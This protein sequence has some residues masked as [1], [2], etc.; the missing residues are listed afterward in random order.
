LSSASSSTDAT[1]KD[2]RGVETIQTGEPDQRSMWSIGIFTGDSPLAV[3]PAPLTR[4]PV[5]TYRDVSDVPASFVADPFMV[6]EGCQWYLFCEVK[7]TQSR[8][9]EIGLATSAD[10]LTWQYLGIVLKEPFH[11]SYPCVFHCAGEYYMVPE[12]LARKAIY[13]YRATRFPFEWRPVGSL[14]EGTFADPT[15]FRHAETWW[16]FACPTPFRHETLCLF[17]AT[18]LHGP[19]RSHPLNP[20]VQGDPRR[21]RPGGRVTQWNGRLIRYAQDCVPLYG[22][23]VRAFEII[24]LTRTTYQEVEISVSPIL[25]AGADVWNRA[26]MHHIDPHAT[27]EGKWIACVDGYCLV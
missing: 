8:F 24:E 12:T 5:L 3:V 20:L 4:N 21:A 22:S 14:V 11:L 17:Y 18:H 6:R 7:N 15:I 13:L 10:G 16:M 2:G 27:P 25:S 19:W 1:G 26:G 23:G 9:G